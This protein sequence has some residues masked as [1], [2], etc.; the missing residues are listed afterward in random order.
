MQ[1][2]ASCQSKLVNYAP[3]QRKAYRGSRKGVGGR[4]P[5]GES[6]AA[7]R[8]R[9]ALQHLV[10]VHAALSET[11]VKRKQTAVGRRV[12]FP[13]VGGVG[14]VVNALL[15]SFRTQAHIIAGLEQAR[16]KNCI[17]LGPAT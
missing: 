8:R 4:K 15:H 16:S 9:V 5:G 1:D 2:G 7:K 6:A 11:Q 10:R 17:S 14:K 13:R 12:R 3:R